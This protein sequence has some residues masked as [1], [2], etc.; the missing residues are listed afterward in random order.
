MVSHI[1]KLGPQQLPT[2]IDFLF[3]LPSIFVWL[4]FWLSDSSVIMIP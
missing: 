4:P 1:Q 3:V 2:I